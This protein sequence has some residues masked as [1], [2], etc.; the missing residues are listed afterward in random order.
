LTSSRG[1]T[2]WASPDDEDNRSDIFST[3]ETTALWTRIRRAR[4]C[5]LLLGHRF[6]E[7]AHD[8]ALL[9]DQVIDAVEPDLSARP[10]A[11]QHAVALL[12]VD[13][14]ELAGFVAATRADGDDLALRGLLLSGVGDDDTTG[15]L[16]F[17]INTLDNNAVV[18]G[19]TSLMFSYGFVKMAVGFG[20]LIVISKSVRCGPAIAEPLRFRGSC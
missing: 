1:T 14:N 9:H 6:L 8:V 20:K 4:S 7:Y 11:E 13:R 16:R 15:G 10:F 17:G 5:G 18:V 19:G 2:F 12:Q 3:V